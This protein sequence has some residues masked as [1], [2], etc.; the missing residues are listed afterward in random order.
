MSL[1]SSS[2]CMKCFVSRLQSKLYLLACVALNYTCRSN[3]FCDRWTQRLTTWS[4][5]GAWSAQMC[6][7]ASA[8]L[9]PAAAA[10]RGLGRHVAST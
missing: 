4:A 10:C 9:H 8:S 6:A 7:T 5:S 3:C 1:A 2:F